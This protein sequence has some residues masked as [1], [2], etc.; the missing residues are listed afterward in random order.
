MA[1][2]LHN[3]VGDAAEE[4]AATIDRRRFLRKA[5]NRTFYAMAVLAAGG[6]WVG[7]MAG[8]AN[9]YPLVC[10]GVIG[11]GCPSDTFANKPCGPSRCCT[12]TTG[13]PSG[14]N[15]QS[16]SPCDSS[17]CKPN[18]TGHCGGKDTSDWANACWTCNGSCHQCGVD[19]FC[20]SVTTCCD[21]K[22]DSACQDG[23]GHCISVCGTTVAC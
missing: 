20:H 6:G 5:A 15:C 19:N 14:C 13:L 1:G 2:S 7:L 9:A 3:I 11:P 8:T 4:V 16:P 17:P 22:T 18:G 12:H 10:E 21:C 23:K